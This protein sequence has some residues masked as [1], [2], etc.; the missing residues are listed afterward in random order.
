MVSAR[1]A[2]IVLRNEQAVVPIGVFHPRF[3]VTLSLPG[4]L[5]RSGVSRILEAA[6]TEQELQGLQRS[7]DT[8]KAA[9]KRI[10]VLADA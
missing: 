4:I 8:L 3:G 6:M 1:I 2:E 10:G 5:G 7:A 9:S